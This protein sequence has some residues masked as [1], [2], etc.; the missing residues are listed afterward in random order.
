MTKKILFVIDRLNEGAGKVVYN[1]ANSLDKNR[2]DV[3][4]VSIY[5]GGI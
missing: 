5:M 4:V 1:I 3:A 2:F